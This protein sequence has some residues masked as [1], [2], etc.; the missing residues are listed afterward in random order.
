MLTAVGICTVDF[1]LAGLGLFSF[2]KVV[3][4]SV[5]WAMLTVFLQL[6]DI[7]TAPQYKMKPLYFAT[8]LFG[9]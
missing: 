3:I 8:Y 5:L 4:P 9:L 6:A 1:I 2:Q 7:I